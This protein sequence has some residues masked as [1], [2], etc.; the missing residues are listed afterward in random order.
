M[1][2]SLFPILVVHLLTLQGT[3]AQNEYNITVALD[4]ISNTLKVQQHMQFQNKSRDTLNQVYLNDWAYAYDN[5]YTPL[6]GRFA[7]EFNS[8][9]LLAKD[10]TRGTNKILSISDKNYDFLD[11]KRLEEQPDIIRVQLRFPIYPGQSHQINSTYEIKIPDAKFTRYGVTKNKEYYLRYWFL[12]YAKRKDGEWKLYSNKDLDDIYLENT[13]YDVKLTSPLGYN[14][15]SGLNVDLETSFG[16]KSVIGFSGQHRTEFQLILTKQETFKTYHTKHLTLVTDIIDEKLPEYKTAL[17]VDRIAVFLNENL[18]AYPHQKIIVTNTE[19]RKNP[20]YGLNQLPSFIRP[21]PDEFQFDIALFKTFCGDYLKKT[22]LLD[23]RKERWILDGIQTYM[24]MKYVDTYYPNMRLSGNLANVWGVRSY[25][26]S[27]M[28]FNEQYPFLAM[29]M[30]RRNND[31]TLDTPAD[32]LVRFNEKISNSYKAGVGLKYLAAYLDDDEKVDSAIKE[33]YRGALLKEVS[34]EDF[35]K[36]LES[37]SDRDISWFVDDYLT[38]RKRIDYKIKKVEKSPDSLRIT[39][40]NKQKNAFPMTLF[41]L[42]NDSV[43][44]K[45][46]LK[47]LKDEATI[48]IPNDGQDKLVLNYD[49]IIP[50]FNQRDNWESLK[51][52]FFNNKPFS[53]KFFKDTEDPYYNQVF[54]VP[55]V[56]FN[57]YDGISPG[58]RFNNK[59]LLRK[60]FF[61]DFRPAYS[62]REKSFIG[63]AN[64]AYTHQ[65]QEK[66]LNSITYGIRGNTFHFAPNSRYETLA[67][68]LSFGFRNPNDFRSN[69]RRSLTFR[70]LIVKRSGEATIETDPDYSVFNSRYT[71]SNIDAIRLMRWS[72]DGQAASDFSKISFNLRYRKLLRDNR[73]FSFR[74]FAGAFIHNDTN[75]DFF[76]FALDRPTDYLFDYDYL[77]RSEDSGIYSQQV[78]IAEGGFKAKLDYPFADDFMMTANTSYSIWRWIEAYGDLGLVSDSDFGTKLVYDSG[79]RL[80]LVEDY[81][82]LYF[83]VYSN[84]GWEIGRPRYDTRIRFVVTLSPRTLFRLFSRKWF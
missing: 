32:S 31:Q 78:I 67:P 40:K 83:P 33:L 17:I 84:N 42:K 11:W 23:P 64:I 49:K 47:D 73:R 79:I 34:Q 36:L 77:G 41:G 26:F 37:K 39:I 72:I 38:T 35:L 22:L 75:S 45:Q 8:S 27:E 6:A 29:Y 50:E 1:K 9:L 15:F 52:F 44:S 43:V 13:N 7:E 57:V 3:W 66:K 60:N 25:H 20:A 63:G 30:A 81:F 19:Y 61:Y 74:F 12:T 71:F 24:M 69:K 62:F 51:G 2:R 21:F 82:E 14:I 68:Y 5:K 16:G 46:W 10:K 53:F 76:S 58:L 28:D 80:N 65:L 70:H 54:F 18:G 56:D 4:T 55:T 59:G 48:T